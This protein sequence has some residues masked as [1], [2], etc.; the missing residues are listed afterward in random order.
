MNRRV[1]I[2]NCSQAYIGFSELIHKFKTHILGILMQWNF[3]KEFIEFMKF[4]Q[5]YHCLKNSQIF[6]PNFKQ[7]VIKEIT[8]LSIHSVAETSQLYSSMVLGEEELFEGRNQGLRRFFF[9]SS[10][11][12]LK[13]FDMGDWWKCRNAWHLLL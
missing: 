2:L 10:K 9:Q 7:V 12:S 13:G 1:H 3:S 8:E 4:S 11:M 5:L 6:F